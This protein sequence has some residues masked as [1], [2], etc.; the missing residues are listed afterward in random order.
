MIFNTLQL[1]TLEFIEVVDYLTYQLTR[2]DIREIFSGDVSMADHIL[3]TKYVP[4]LTNG[5]NLTLTFLR[6]L[7]HKNQY[8]LINF[9]I[10]KVR[11]QLLQVF[12]ETNFNKGEK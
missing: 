3:E 7:D 11:H 2:E 4:Y 6:S 5:N 9:C 8:K 12:A 1:T 10:N